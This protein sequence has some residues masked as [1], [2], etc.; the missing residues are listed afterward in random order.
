MEADQ[1]QA[2]VIDNQRPFQN[3]NFFFHKATILSQPVIVKVSKKFFEIVSELEFARICRK[4]EAEWELLAQCE[5]PNV[6]KALGIFW[7]I[8][9]SEKIPHL[10]FEAGEQV[11]E[12]YL[13]KKYKKLPSTEVVNIFLQVHMGMKYLESK[14][15]RTIL[16][17]QQI[18]V[19]KEKKGELKN[20]YKLLL[21]GEGM[22]IQCLWEL[23]L[24]NCQFDADAK[25]ILGDCYFNGW[26]VEQD[27]CKAAEFYFQAANQGHSNAQCNLGV[28]YYE[29]F[30]VPQNYTKAAEFYTLAANQGNS[31]AQY[32]LANYYSSGL[33][34]VD[35]K[36]AAE[37]YTQ[38]ANQGDVS[39]QFNL[40]RCYTN[41]EGVQVD[42]QKALYYFMEAAKQGHASGQFMVGTC[43]AESLGV[44]MDM[45]QAVRYYT[46]AANQG[47]SDAQ[48]KLGNCYKSGRGVEKDPKKAAEFHT[49]AA[50]QGHSAAQFFLG[51]CYL[52]GQGVEKDGNEAVKLLTYWETSTC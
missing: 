10:I 17:P 43:F 45:Q 21:G 50:N 36:R 7:K 39:A 41:G 34:P 5:H 44:E 14:G 13:S 46:L 27:H 47:D 26:G 31:I 52:S 35:L 29:G 18:T 15:V 22:S 3:E 32:N 42:L 24:S 8:E 33:G 9:G 19:S 40:G 37:L 12:E 2:L 48:F 23:L 51:I 16:H 30:G 25:Y 49:Q 20:R 28:C 4:V 6:A 11:L 1:L 38:A